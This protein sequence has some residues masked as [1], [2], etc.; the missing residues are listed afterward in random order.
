M[1]T[2][3]F[4]KCTWC[5]DVTDEPLVVTDNY[6]LVHDGDCRVALERAIMIEELYEN[7]YITLYELMNP[8][9]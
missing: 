1:F 6:E 7:G 8:E 4:Y 3:Q 5:A 9:E 2:T